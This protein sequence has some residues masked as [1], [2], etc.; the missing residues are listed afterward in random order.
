MRLIR[1]KTRPQFLK[2][3]A[4]GR[5]AVRPTLL[6]QALQLPEAD[7]ARARRIARVVGQEPA[8][9]LGFTASKKV[10][11]AVARNRAKRRLTALAQDM[12]PSMAAPGW[13]LVLIARSTT[14]KAP[15]ASLEADMRSALRSV[16]KKPHVP[17]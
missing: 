14:V 2:I 9:F 8:V 7:Q 16:F 6:M 11:N 10:G 5:K 17:T 13:G 12:V 3:A 15:F 4:K 1:L